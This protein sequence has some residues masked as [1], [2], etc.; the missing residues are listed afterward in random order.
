MNF[1]ETIDSSFKISIPET[2]CKKLNLHTQEQVLITFNESTNVIS[3]S[4]YKNDCMTHSNSYKDDSY[5]I[6]NTS[7]QNNNKNKITAYTSGEIYRLNTEISK[8]VF[9]STDNEKLNN[10][11]SVTWVNGVLVHS[12]EKITNSTKSDNFTPGEF[13]IDKIVKSKLPKFKDTDK[14]SFRAKSDIIYDIYCT[15]CNKEIE[16]YSYIKLNGKLLCNS[17][18]SDLKN[19]LKKD[20]QILNAI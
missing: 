19:Q 13:P 11:D 15:R 18:V 8:N 7:N 9:N 6:I 2:I 14:I 3:L 16:E 4:K 1:I 12:K 5:S 17:C 10:T 20:I